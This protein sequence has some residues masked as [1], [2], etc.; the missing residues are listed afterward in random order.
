MPLRLLH[1]L[2]F[3]LL[4]ALNRLPIPVLLGGEF[5]DPLAWRQHLQRLQLA[6]PQLCHVMFE[7]F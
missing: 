7:L 2:L 6:Q 4:V 5:R 3:F 1:N